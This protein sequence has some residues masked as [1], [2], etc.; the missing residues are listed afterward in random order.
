FILNGDPTIKQFGV[1]LSVAVLLAGVLVVTLAP[2]ALTLFGRAAWWLPR[3]LDRLLPHISVEGDTPSRPPPDPS[4][5][6]KRP[7]SSRPAPATG[8]RLPRRGVSRTHR[9]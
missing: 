5:N 6:G 9:R 8:I 1:G 4:A 2:A 7:V 3:W